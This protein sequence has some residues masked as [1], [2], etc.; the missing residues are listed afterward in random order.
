M[1]QK[2][3]ITKLLKSVTEIYY[4][5]YYK[6]YQVLQSVIDCYYKVH[7]VLQSVTLSLSTASGITRY[8]NYYKVRRNTFTQSNSVRGAV[9][10][11]F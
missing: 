3:V 5:V 11:I 2:T 8:H 7:Q 6:V 1:R 10:K 4:K 9:L